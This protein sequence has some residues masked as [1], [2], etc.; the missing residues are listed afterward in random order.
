MQISCQ[1]GNYCIGRAFAN[2]YGSQT[3][4]SSF[5]D[6]P[7]L[8]TKARLRVKLAAARIFW[9]ITFDGQGSYRDVL[10]GEWLEASQY[11]YPVEDTTVMMIR[12]EAT[13]FSS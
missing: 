4:G 5:F 7:Q 12:Q 2:N 11:L 9:K 13:C 8:P 6:Y 1:P 3:D 10:R